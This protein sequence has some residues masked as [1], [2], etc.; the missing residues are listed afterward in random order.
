[1]A[2]KYIDHP[3]QGCLL[4]QN[5]V[6]SS[7]G[8]MHKE[9]TQKDRKGKKKKGYA[10]SLISNHL[11][12]QKGNPLKRL[13][14]QNKKAHLLMSCVPQKHIFQKDTF[15]QYTPHVLISAL[16]PDL[17]NS[18]SIYFVN[19]FNSY[20]LYI[21]RFCPFYKTVGMLRNIIAF[22]DLARHAV[23]STAQS[24][25][26]ITWAIIRDHM[27]DTIYK[28]SSMKF[29]VSEGFVEAPFPPRPSLG[30]C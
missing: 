21:F 15:L 2:K 16:A 27:S 14:L 11:I 3:F 30:Q 6:C 24:D 13:R 4:I 10:I 19:P 26:K 20:H 28:L 25:N 8:G 5:D 17:V 9:R 29:K 22:Y 7:K 12:P 18:T 1:M 23:E